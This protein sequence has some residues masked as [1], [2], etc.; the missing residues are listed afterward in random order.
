MAKVFMRSMRSGEATKAPP[1]DPPSKP[2]PFRSAADINPVP[3]LEEIRQF[4]LLSDFVL[5]HILGAKFAQHLKGSLTDLLQ[6]SLLW[7]VHSLALF[8]FKAKLEPIVSVSGCLFLLYDHT[9]T[10]FDHRNRDKAAI[11]GKE[12][13]H[14]NLLSYETC[15]LLLVLSF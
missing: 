15:H 13:G 7:F 10:R 11:S 6:M 5:R 1:L 9:R 2:S 4:N 8:R 14:P 12:L 3:R